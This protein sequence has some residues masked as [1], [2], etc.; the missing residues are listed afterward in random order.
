MRFYAKRALGPTTK[1][2]RI[3]A[4]KC[5]KPSANC[6][7]YF[8]SLSNVF[9][10][11]LFANGDRVQSNL[12]RCGVDPNRVCTTRTPEGEKFNISLVH[13]FNC[14]SFRFTVSHITT[15]TTTTTTDI[16]EWPFNRFWYIQ[17]IRVRRRLLEAGVH[18]CSYQLFNFTIQALWWLVAPFRR[19]I[20]WSA[21][22]LQHRRYAVCPFRNLYLQ[23]EG[24]WSLYSTS[25]FFFIGGKRAELN[26][27]QPNFHKS[28]LR[29]ICNQAKLVD[30]INLGSLSIN[31]LW[32]NQ[33]LVR[34]IITPIQIS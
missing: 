23:L 8:D 22:T 20:E 34:P 21:S 32:G 27:S 11:S 28:T 17:L 30:N 31:K 10:S 14:V 1:A 3:P 18:S 12:G 9:F 13:A 6:A 16:E 5:R 19:S 26:D 29:L 25:S 7:K 4:D 33:N 24:M 2:A 15:T